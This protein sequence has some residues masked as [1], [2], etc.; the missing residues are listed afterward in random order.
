VYTVPRHRGPPLPK[1]I[2]SP[3][4]DTFLTRSRIVPFLVF[5]FFSSLFCVHL[6]LFLLIFSFSF[7]FPYIFPFFS[8]FFNIFPNDIS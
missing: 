6:T 1:I 5:T 2:V 3:T 4:R 8:S 7:A